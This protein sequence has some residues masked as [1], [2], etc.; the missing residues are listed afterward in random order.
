VS[1]G[2]CLGHRRLEFFPPAL[3]VFSSG[4]KKAGKFLLRDAA[5]CIGRAAALTDDAAASTG[6][7][8]TRTNDTSASA[9][10]A[11]TGTDDAAAST[12][13]VA[14]RTNDASACASHATTGTNHTAVSTGHAATRT[15]D[16]AT[17]ASYAATRHTA[18]GAGQSMKVRHSDSLILMWR[19]A[20]LEAR[21][22]NDLSS[23]KWS[24]LF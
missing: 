10:H 5:T 1:R 21:Q 4:C 3:F 2:D 22:L 6:H 15:N 18:G 7:A 11:T 12:G 14:T 13:H 17:C 8:A 24:G 9:S 16:T 19:L 23:K 20:E